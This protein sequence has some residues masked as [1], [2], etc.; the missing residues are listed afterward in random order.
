MKV[1]LD[2]MARLARKAMKWAKADLERQAAVDRTLDPRARA[3][4][5][6][7]TNFDLYSLSWT[8]QLSDSGDQLIVFTSIRPGMKIWFPYEKE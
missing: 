7:T 6:P 5:A 4:S 3:H 1:N 2:N 8:V